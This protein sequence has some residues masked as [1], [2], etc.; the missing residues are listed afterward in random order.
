MDFIYFH[1][2]EILNLYRA[3]KNHALALT[4]INFVC[5]IEVTNMKLF[6]FD[7]REFSIAVYA[8]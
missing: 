5:Q 6:F 4:Y 2:A 7:N 3:M 1:F 8:H